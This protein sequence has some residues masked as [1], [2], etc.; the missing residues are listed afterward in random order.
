MK[1]VGIDPS[2]RNTGLA[3]LDEDQAGACPTFYEIKTRGTDLLTSVRKIREEFAAF[4]EANT[5]LDDVAFS[6][7]KVVVSGHS[8]QLLFYVQM[9]LFEV[10]QG[11][12]VQCEPILINPL[13]VQ[14]RSYI[15]H[16]YRIKL[17]GTQKGVVVN[18]FKEKYG[19]AWGIQRIS[20]HC[21]EAFF[22]A[23][24][25]LEVLAHEW[26]YN[27]PQREPKLVPWNVIY[28]VKYA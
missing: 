21:V 17:V 19:K 25:G 24:M 10:I 15:W 12:F 20:S 23:K 26:D 9:A 16:R 2:Q 6:M 28:G 1:V 3:L 13:P 22:L 5:E 7:E 8:S 4:V 11:R 18:G 27:A 14:L